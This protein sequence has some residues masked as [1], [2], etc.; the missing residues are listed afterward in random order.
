MMRLF[1]RSAGYN[2]DDRVIINGELIIVVD[3]TNVSLYGEQPPRYILINSSFNCIGIVGH[4]NMSTCMISSIILGQLK[5]VRP[6]M[7]SSR[8]SHGV[9]QCIARVV[10][11]STLYRSDWFSERWVLSDA[12]SCAAD[13]LR[14]AFDQW[15]Y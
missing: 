6:G 15:L 4:C 3:R 7:C 1:V 13:E 12:P 5:S 8:L 2:D 14:D 9:L 11:L 10:D